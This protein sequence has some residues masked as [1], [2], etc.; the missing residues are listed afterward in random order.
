MQKNKLNL[1]IYGIHLLNPYKTV[2]SHLNIIDIILNAQLPDD[3]FVCFQFHILT[4]YCDLRIFII[5]PQWLT[6]FWTKTMKKGLFSNIWT[7]GIHSIV[8]L[9][10]VYIFIMYLFCQLL[11]N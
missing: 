8:L 5:L 9:P 3:F 2:V 1:H 11:C 6:Q 4:S 10:N 7:S